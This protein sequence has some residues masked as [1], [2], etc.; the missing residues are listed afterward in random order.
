MP[1]PLP[2]QWR[3]CSK[4]FCGA[5]NA[6][7]LEHGSPVPIEPFARRSLMSGAAFNGNNGRNDDV[8]YGPGVEVAAMTSGAIATASRI[9]EVMVPMS[10]G[11]TAVPV[12]R[13]RTRAER[14]SVC[15][16]RCRAAR[17]SVT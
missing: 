16:S 11:V 9:S 13:A 12:G 7:P 8:D 15:G 14:R 6:K 1:P 10:S 5:A 4:G 3:R 17:S 2:P